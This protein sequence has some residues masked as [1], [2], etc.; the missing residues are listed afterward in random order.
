MHEVNLN[1]VANTL[2]KDVMRSECMFPSRHHS[3]VFPRLLGGQLPHGECFTNGR[4]FRRGK[5]DDAVIRVFLAVIRHRDLPHRFPGA[6]FCHLAGEVGNDQR[7]AVAVLN[8][9]CRGI[10]AMF[11]RCQ[12]HD[13]IA[14]AFDVTLRW[15]DY[16]PL[17]LF[18][19]S[20]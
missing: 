6:T 12:A 5:T 20:F 10:E 18:N 7:I 13:G 19:R 16:A 3:E 4:I 8:E 11:L 2:L 9:L 1:V 17:H 15:E 14:V